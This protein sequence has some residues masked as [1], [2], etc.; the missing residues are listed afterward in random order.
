MAPN[1]ASIKGRTGEE[2]EQ[3]GRKMSF[4]PPG[5]SN[6]GWVCEKAEETGPEQREG[7]R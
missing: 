2:E 1:G 7:W 3:Q 5:V 6:F 4:E